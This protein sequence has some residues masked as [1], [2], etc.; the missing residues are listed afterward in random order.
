M[1]RYNKNKKYRKGYK[2][3]ITKTKKLVTGQTQPTLLEKI[4]A[5]SGSIA[6]VAKAVMPIV[7]MIN[8]E[9]KF[10]DAVATSQNISST[11]AF[12]VLMNPTQG[13]GETNRIGTSVLLKNMNL[14]VS[15]SPNYTAVPINIFRMVVFVD[16]FQAGSLPTATQLFQA[17]TNIDSAFNKNF[18]DR[19]A[20][21]KD[22]RFIVTQ[23]GN[24]E[25]LIQK[26][27]KQLDF[28]QRFIGIDG[29]QASQ[30]PNSIYL[31]MWGTL[32]VNFPTLSIYCRTNFTDN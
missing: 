6:S 26:Y 13:T 30:G 32:S 5:Q 1:A 12:Y 24:Q 28:H 8:T 22:K 7:S 4:A 11:P 16:K 27:F 31:C 17:P 2:K 3:G 29:S 19:F 14:R 9:Q 25:Q 18:T 10:F 15:I 20:I 21:L 23:Q